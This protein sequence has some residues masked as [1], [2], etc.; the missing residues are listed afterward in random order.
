MEK[1]DGRRGGLAPHPVRE[2]DTARLHGEDGRIEEGRHGTGEGARVVEPREVPRAPLDR[3]LAV[4]EERGELRRPVRARVPVVLPGEDEHRRRQLTEGGDGG[5]GVVRTVAVVAAAR[6]GV[7]LPGGGGGVGLR[8]RVPA[9]VGER[10][11]GGPQLGEGPSGEQRLLGGPGL[12]V[13]GFAAAQ[14]GGHSEV[15]VG[16][17]DAGGP[18]GGGDQGEGAQPLRVPGGVQL[19]QVRTGGVGQQVDPVQAEVFAQRLHV[20]HEP[21]AAVG[22][23]VLRHGGTARTPQIEED[24][25]P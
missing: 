3:E 16:H 6:L 20:V 15:L 19:G 8:G 17:L 14:F 10:P 23:R 25:L 18:G 24:Q 11:D 1:D 4:R 12:G 21:V 22:R 7:G 2:P 5:G 9:A 13:P